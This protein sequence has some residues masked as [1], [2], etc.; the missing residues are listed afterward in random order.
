[1]TATRSTT[2]RARK[3]H[4][5]VHCAH[6]IEAG[7]LYIGWTTFG[8]DG[9]HSLRAHRLC[10][11]HWRGREICACWIFEIDM[12]DD[13][14]PPPHPV[15]AD[16]EANELAQWADMWGARRCSHRS[17]RLPFHHRRQHPRDHGI[18]YVPLPGSGPWEVSVWPHPQLSETHHT[19]G[20]IPPSL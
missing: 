4:T 18:R 13:G 2:R 9:V 3:P 8:D 6:A 15:V 20:N 19:P 17:H 7:M 11:A 14:P 12:D 16:P 10:Q 1:M 5:C